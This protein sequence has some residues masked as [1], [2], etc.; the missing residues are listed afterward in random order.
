MTFIPAW[1]SKYGDI[2]V[3]ATN[4]D[5]ESRLFFDNLSQLDAYPVF[6]SI[7]Q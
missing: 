2:V 7:Y 6:D 1:A 5:I 4:Q 3:E